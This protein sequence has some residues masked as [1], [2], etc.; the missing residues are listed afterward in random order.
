MKIIQENV[1]VLKADLRN[2]YLSY[3]QIFQ[4]H[5]VDGTS[6]FF[7]HLLK[8][9]YRE[10]KLRHLVAEYLEVHIH[11]V[12][13]VGSSK[14][15][16][17]LSPKNAFRHFDEEFRRTKN[18]RSKS[19]LDIAVVSD[20]LFDNL[21]KRVF[22][23]TDSFRTKWIE[24]EYYFD[25]RLSKLGMPVYLKYFEYA[26]KGWFRPDMKPKGFEFCSLDGYQSLTQKIFAEFRRKL[27]LG[28]YKDWYFFKHYHIDNIKRLS[29]KLKVDII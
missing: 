14:L 29:N 12:I 21:T 3:E 19:D 10:Y 16:Y 15:G 13:I 8:D 5:I 7:E 23:Y 27:G 4:K 18:H 2:G 9:S 26:S 1:D 24:N 25:D 28:V 20:R 6:Y 11:E 17:S 22:E